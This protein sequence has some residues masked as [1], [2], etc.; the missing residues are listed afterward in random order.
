MLFKIFAK[1]KQTTTEIYK[2][3]SF[4]NALAIGLVFFFCLFAS[5]S[6]AVEGVSTTF[7]PADFKGKCRVGNL[8]CLKNEVD[9]FA[10]NG[11]LLPPGLF[12]SNYPDTK[13][14]KAD[15]EKL[16]RWKIRDY[17]RQSPIHK[18]LFLFTKMRFRADEQKSGKVKIQLLWGKTERWSVL[19]KYQRDVQAAQ[20]NTRCNEKDNQYIYSSL[21]DKYNLRQRTGK[22]CALVEYVV[23]TQHWDLL[24]SSE[25]IN[26]LDRAGAFDRRAGKRRR[27]F[28]EAQFL[29]KKVDYRLKPGKDVTYQVIFKPIAVLFDVGGVRQVYDLVDSPER[30][31]SK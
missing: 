5:S 19:N 9:F 31:V 2:M 27:S 15:F 7:S 23:Q 22:I 12:Y 17:Q 13:D 11:K 14:A 29:V 21:I 18:N 24:L 1:Q 10:L 25:M 3:K 8:T 28:P 26:A 20:F 4:K 30:Y 6:W 16:E